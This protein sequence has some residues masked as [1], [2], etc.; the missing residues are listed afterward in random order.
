MFSKTPAYL[1]LFFAFALSFSLVVFQ[2]IPQFNYDFE[3]FFPQDD[4]D[5]DFYQNFKKQFENDNDYLLLA[6]DN[7]D[8]ELFRPDFLNRSMRIQEAIQQL[9]KIDTVISIL[10]LEQPIIGVF[11]LRNRKV[12]DWNDEK[13]LDKTS[14]NL[15]QYRSGLISKDGKSILIYV[16]NAQ[17]IS[18]TDGDIL[19]AAIKAVFKEQGIQPKAIAGK[20]QTQ[21][22][23]V[24]LM[25]DEFGLFFGCSIVL[26]LILLV[27]IFRSVWGV[28][29]PLIVLII[30]V[31]WAFGLLIFMGKPL[32]VMSVMQPTIFMIVGLSA[33]IHFF[34]HLIKKLKEGTVKEQAIREVFNELIVPV[35]LTILTTSLGFISLYFTSIPALQDFGW[36]TGL[37]VLIM[38]GALILVAPGLLYLFPITISR[39]TDKLERPSV[40]L[41]IFSWQLKHKKWIKFSFLGITLACIALGSTLKINGYLLDN[42]PLNH[43]IQQDFEY[44]N[45]QY[46]G[47]NPLEIYVAVGNGATSLLDYEVLQELEKVENKILELFGE[48]QIISPLTLVKSIN[49]AQNQGDPKAF[50]MPSR[51]QRQRMNQW[52]EVALE[53][54]DSKVI[55]KNRKSGRISARTPDLGS[56][57]MTELRDE[58]NQF[59]REEIDSDLIYLRW[60]GTAHLIDKGHRSVT[61]QMAKG[62][63]VAFLLVGIIVGFL[64]RSWR[65]SFLL[66]IPNFIPLIWLLGLMYLLGIEFKLTTA[67]LFTVAFGIAVDDSIHFMSRLKQELSLGKNL[68]YALK[69]T[70]LETGKAIVLTTV[71][72]TAGFSLLIFSQFGVTHFTGLLI[73]ASMIFALLADLMLLPLL[74]LPLKKM[75]ENK[76]KHA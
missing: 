20:I 2:P 70:F 59:V 15:E 32:D 9:D 66:L 57:K 37:G 54:S 6:L 65:I 7:P 17:N 33:L 60:T 23:F 18:K 42:L 44:F 39:V 40:L 55:S 71:I 34:T 51:G 13:S 76:F 36:S 19:Y 52:L 28:L 26:M 50:T 8:G 21:G 64:F 31:A 4:E 68:I 35:W 46:G 45:T 61:L 43:P 53:K 10:N 16:R 1:L 30:G 67:I 5:L 38:F 47:S 14:K 24:Q 75:W 73:S 63:G 25:Q 69:R 12:L 56:L 62:L 74:L 58:L 3:T 29:I 48:G 22:D 27:L 41:F 11:G 72:L 49:Q